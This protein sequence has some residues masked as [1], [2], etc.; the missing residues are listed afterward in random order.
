MKLSFST[1]G[2]PDWS[3][4]QIAQNAREMG[5]NGVELRTHDD[6]NHLSPHATIEEARSVGRIFRDAGVPV[7][8]ILSYARFACT[9]DAEVAKNQALVRKQ[10]VLA[11]ALGAKHI[12]V[13]AGR[14]PPGV[15]LSSNMIEKVGLALKPLA[16]EAASRG[17]V[18][19]IETHDDWC[20]G[21][22]HVRLASII[23]N[24]TGCGVIYDIRNALEAK[25]EP[26]DVTYAKI[27]PLLLYCHVK[28]G[29]TDASGKLVCMPFGAGATPW[30]Q[31]L[32]TLKKDGFDGYFS[33]EWE[34][35]WH[36]ELEPPERVYPAY[37]HKMN[38]LWNDA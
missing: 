14:L 32:Q 28:D 27:K 9:D 6:G 22:V 37:V 8:S 23:N 1:L 19:G 30:R 18:I 17:V 7:F 4:E 3:L 25:L 5:F 35:K 10:I 2:C 38:A 12:R 33:F 11:E 34:K 13:F 20:A 29:Y 36:P 24:P 31:I 21:D 26:W 16:A 15:A